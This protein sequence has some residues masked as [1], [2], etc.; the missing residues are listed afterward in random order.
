MKTGFYNLSHMSTLI[1]KKFFKDA[2]ML[3]YDSHIDVLDCN[4]SWIRQR[5]TEVSLKDI[6]VLCDKK[7]HNVCIDRTVQ[8]GRI[9]RYGEVGFSFTKNEKSYFL[10]CFLTMKD[11]ETLI[12]M[13][14][15]TERE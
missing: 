14:N 9:D 13:Y 4:V 10:Y 15:L 8:Y 6:L 7:H 5:Y 3:S 11:L 12:S 1:L 2:I